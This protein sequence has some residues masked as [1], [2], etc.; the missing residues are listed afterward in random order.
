MQ[1][2]HLPSGALDLFENVRC[3]CGPD[4]RLLFSAEFYEVVVDGGNQLFDTGEANSLEPILGD[5]T[6]ESFDHV[7]P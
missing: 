2:I 6:E 1:L 7:E 3:H 4:K 5:V